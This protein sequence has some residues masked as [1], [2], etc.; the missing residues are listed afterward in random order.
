MH[1]VQTSSNKTSQ[2]TKCWTL[3]DDKQ[4][5]GFAWSIFA[6][7]F[8]PPTPQM[9]PER[10]KDMKLRVNQKAPLYLILAH[11]FFLTELLYYLLILC[12]CCEPMGSSCSSYSAPQTHFSQT[13]LVLLFSYSFT[14][15][16]KASSIWECIFSE[17]YYRAI[18]LRV[19]YISMHTFSHELVFHL[20]Q[21]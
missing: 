8:S 14:P 12:L 15:L 10:K 18:F 17:E 21:L 3:G 7:F 1:N 6:H 4:N 9:W 13:C 11:T 19:I 16:R 2:T 20:D 5:E